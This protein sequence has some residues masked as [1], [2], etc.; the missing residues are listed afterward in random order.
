MV[1]KTLYEFSKNGIFYRWDDYSLQIA[2]ISAERGGKINKD[3]QNPIKETDESKKACRLC[4]P[5]E[6]DKIPYLE[7]LCDGKVACFGNGAPYLP[8]DQK[9]LFLW[10]DN[11]EIR[12]NILHRCNAEDLRREEIFYTL[13]AAREK[14]REFKSKK[15]DSHNPMTMTFGMNLGEKA[16]M[17]LLHFHTQYGWRVDTAR[18]K[19][20]FQ[21]IHEDPEARKL[22]RDLFYRELDLE[23]LVVYNGSNFRIISPWTPS[24]ACQYELHFKDKFEIVDLSDDD[25]KIISHVMVAGIKNYREKLGIE[26]FNITIKNSSIGETLT[27][28]IVSLV[29]RTNTPALYEKTTNENVVDVHPS[30][31]A[32]FLN[33]NINWHKEINE[34]KRYSPEKELEARFK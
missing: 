18:V 16:G 34:A 27:P 10:N 3:K 5:R 1:R 29:P 28:V 4:H 22:A 25:L 15:I 9:V 31:T 7:Y 24:D 6:L 8:N 13:Y 26:N 11:L 21:N 23:D 20:L 12:E 14:G 19:Q 30:T 33:N 2:V 32:R 17:S